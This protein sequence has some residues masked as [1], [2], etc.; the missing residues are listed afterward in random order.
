MEVVE[1]SDDESGSE[2]GEET[3]PAPA[4]R[5]RGNTSTK[6]PSTPS[7]VKAVCVSF[8]QFRISYLAFYHQWKK[9]EC[10]HCQSRRRVNS[11]PEVC[12]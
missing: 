12:T 7:P 9:K 11:H 8:S 2:G 4:S 5:M 3:V 10:P 1:I 6:P